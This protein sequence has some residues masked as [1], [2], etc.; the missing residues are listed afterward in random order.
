M[1]KRDAFALAPPAA[2][3]HPPNLVDQSLF[4]FILNLEM[5]KAMRLQYCFSV[6]CVAPDL[7]GKG[8]AAAI[9]RLAEVTTRQ[10]RA[11]D[12]GASYLPSCIALLLIDAEPRNLSGILARITEAVETTP[13]GLAGAGGMLTFSGGGGCYP[14]T[15]S[16]SGELLRQA[17]DLMER[18]QRDGGNRLYLPA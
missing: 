5:H 18:A 13:L 12:L 15:A 16:N 2:N 10:L 11:L 3:G 4:D 14:K 8:T 1:R 7:R 6:L 9:E 17:I